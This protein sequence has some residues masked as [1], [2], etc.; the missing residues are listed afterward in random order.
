M[1]YFKYTISRDDKTHTIYTLSVSSDQNSP[2]SNYTVS[3]TEGVVS[4]DL[5]DKT[6]LEWAKNQLKEIKL[7]EITKE[8]FEPLRK[9]SQE[10]PQEWEI[11]KFNRGEELA[12]SRVEVNKIILDADEESMNRIDRILTILSS[13]FNKALAEGKDAKTAWQDVYVKQTTQWKANNNEFVSVNGE[14]LLASQQAALNKM[15]E[16]WAK[17]N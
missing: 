11:I 5:D 6:T 9:K 13:Q 10:Y 7:T 14:V 15:Q 4:V 2:F 8:E 1:K 17:Y 16:L 3:E 12:K